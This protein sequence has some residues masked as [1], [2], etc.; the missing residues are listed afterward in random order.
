MSV[1]GQPRGYRPQSSDTDADAERYLF[2]RLRS[3]PPWRKAE[4]LSA[5]TRSAYSLAMTG[6]RQRYPSATETEL[7]KRYAALVLGRDVSMALFDWDPE[8]E[9]W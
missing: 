1:P 3:L 7:R 8:R 5:S 4:M 6:L 9:G 2:D